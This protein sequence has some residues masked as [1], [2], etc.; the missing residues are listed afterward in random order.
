MISKVLE[1]LD[2]ENIHISAATVAHSSGVSK[3]QIL[4]W[5]KAGHLS[6]Q[7]GEYLMFP[8]SVILKAKIMGVL[9]NRGGFRSKNAAILATHLIDRFAD[10]PDEAKAV[11]IFLASLHERFDDVIKL[12]IKTDFHQ[13]ILQSFAPSEVMANDKD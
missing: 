3:S 11:L 12:M 9:V 4:Y 1:S 5:A 10:N 8:L 2:V 7:T 6:H 13:R